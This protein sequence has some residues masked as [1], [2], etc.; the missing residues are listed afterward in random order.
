MR[1][2]GGVPCNQHLY[3]LVRLIL[4]FLVLITFLHFSSSK[5][6]LKEAKHSL[7]SPPTS[8]CVFPC[9]EVGKEMKVCLRPCLFTLKPTIGSSHTCIIT[10]KPPAKKG[11][12][13]EEERE[14]DSESSSS[15]TDS[16]TNI[17]R[18]FIA[19]YI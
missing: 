8:T 7:V 15:S 12:W 17:E 18:L 14:E 4:T 9:L 1:S 3:E 5:T 2:G 16:D 11:H 19:K 13:E 6:Y 10:E